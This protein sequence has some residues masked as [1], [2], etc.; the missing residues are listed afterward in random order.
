MPSRRFLSGKI[1]RK[2]NRK[3]ILVCPVDLESSMAI[4]PSGD[5]PFPRHASGS[6]PLLFKWGDCGPWTH[7]R[8]KLLIH[9]LSPVSS[10]HQLGSD[11]ARPTHEYARSWDIGNYIEVEKLVRPSFSSSA[12]SP[13]SIKL[14]YCTDDTAR[15]S[16]GLLPLPRE[17]GYW[18]IKANS[19]VVP[20][21][22]IS[23]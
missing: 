17:S 10:R 8:S 2:L 9:Y 5:I 19:R 7:Q 21:F 3:N 4:S 12:K 23:P 16:D 14:L 15:S 22:V 13:D 6:S 20:H 1:V 18:K 11:S